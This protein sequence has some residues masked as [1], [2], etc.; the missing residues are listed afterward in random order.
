MRALVQRAPRAL[1]LDEIDDPTPAPG[2]VVVRTSAVGICGSDLKV[3]DIAAYGTG[4]VLGHEVAGVVESVGDGVDP[5]LIGTR[6]AIHGGMSCGECEHCLDDLPYYCMTGLGLGSRQGVGGFAERVVVPAENVLPISDATDLAAASF[7]EPLA[8][9]LRL[10]DRPE[11][12]GTHGALILGAGPIGLV[13]LLA[14][15]AKGV[16][17]IVVVEGRHRRADAALSLGA[18]RVI[19]PGDDVER[20]V[21]R[22]MPGGPPIVIEA[23]GHPATVMQAMKLTRPGGS[24][25]LMGVCGEPVRV[26][27]FRWMTK[28]LTIRTSIGTDLERHAEAT[29]LIDR[30]DVDASALI[31]SRITLDEAPDA[32]EALAGGAD[33]IKVVVEHGR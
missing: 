33:E 32:F 9:G 26:N 4:V 28:E 29:Q 10:L 3:W 16:T 7:A 8:N 24:A 1:E 5:S 11:V 2:Q 22:S 21:R 6:A 19:D 20:E 30:G 23:V 31:T 14:A 27:P 13:S 17:G 18:E 25:F 15:R 12:P